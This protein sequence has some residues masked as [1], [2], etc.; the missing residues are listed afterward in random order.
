[1]KKPEYKWGRLHAKI[2]D[3]FIREL[4]SENIK[5]F[6]LRNYEGLPDVNESK[7]ID[8]IIEPGKYSCAAQLLLRI[9][10]EYTMDCNW[11]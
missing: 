11:I 6:I 5:Y 1:M 8:L 2:F 9:F 10:E 4:N 3:S 7:D